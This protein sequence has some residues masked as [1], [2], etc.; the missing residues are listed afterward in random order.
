ML[1]VALSGR[2]LPRVFTVSSSSHL[3]FL[4]VGLRTYRVCVFMYE[5]A[6]LCKLL[7]VGHQILLFCVWGGTATCDPLPTTNLSVLQERDAHSPM[8][9][10]VGLLKKQRCFFCLLHRSSCGYVLVPACPSTAEKKMFMLMLL[11]FQYCKQP[12]LRRKTIGVPVTSKDHARMHLV[13]ALA[14]AATPP[15]ADAICFL[16]VIRS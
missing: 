1:S 9:P 14:R 3:S 7:L 13:L 2:A 6:Y 11:F 5:F 8:Y 16:L 10:Y 4:F 15:T 12:D